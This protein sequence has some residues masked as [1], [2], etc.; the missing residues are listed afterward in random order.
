[1]NWRMALM[2]SQHSR[3]SLVAA[4]ALS[5]RQMLRLWLEP[6]PLA[7]F[8][9]N[10]PTSQKNV[11]SVQQRKEEVMN[12]NKN[13]ILGGFL[14]L[15]FMSC[16][17]T[18]QE[19]PNATTQGFGPRPAYS[20]P[21]SS[22]AQKVAGGFVGQGLEITVRPDL[23]SPGSTKLNLYVCSDF[24]ERSLTSPSWGACIKR[25]IAS[26]GDAVRLTM[27]VPQFSPRNPNMR[28]AIYAENYD[29]TVNHTFIL[30]DITVI[31]N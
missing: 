24:W 1:M 10:S 3:L 27:V 6:K 21:A 22:L 12:T 4:R 16:G 19:S 5:Q 11:F 23:Y 15:G 31:R 17:T 30:N 28:V 7:A 9:K 25:V 26:P 8:P 20:V 18:P 14:A 2:A 29:T 13:M